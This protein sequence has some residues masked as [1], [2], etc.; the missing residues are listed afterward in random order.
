M[1]ITLICPKQSNQVDYWSRHLAREQSQSNSGIIG[2][3]PHKTPNCKLTY[4][5]YRIDSVTFNEAVLRPPLILTTVLRSGNT[6]DYGMLC[7]KAMALNC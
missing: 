3:Y 1:L 5:Q 6:L 4:C 7:K 2:P